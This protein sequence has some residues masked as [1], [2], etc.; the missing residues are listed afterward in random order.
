MT[1]KVLI[2]V[3]LLKSKNVTRNI[4]KNLQHS[5]TKCY[6]NYGSRIFSIKVFLTLF[7][8]YLTATSIWSYILCI[9]ANYNSTAYNSYRLQR[10]GFFTIKINTKISFICLKMHFRAFFPR[11]TANI[12][13]GQKTRARKVHKVITRVS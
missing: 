9:A 13:Q 10:S 11:K 2:A 5:F 8:S 12:K 7:L 6:N 4:A 1:P 3:S